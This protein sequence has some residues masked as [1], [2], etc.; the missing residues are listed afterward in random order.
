MLKA[1]SMK[2]KIIVILIFF[3]LLGIVIGL[4]ARC[5]HIDQSQ[6]F[7]VYPEKGLELGLHSSGKN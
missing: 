6:K 7:S 1:H 4:M 5:T 3:V 2:K